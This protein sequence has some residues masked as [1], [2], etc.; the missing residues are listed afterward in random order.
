[1]IKKTKRLVEG[2]IPVSAAYLRDVLFNTAMLRSAPASI[3]LGVNK[4]PHLRLHK[5][6]GGGGGYFLNHMSLKKVVKW[7]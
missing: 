1:M 7:P 2:V 3:W 5:E 4:T 6:G